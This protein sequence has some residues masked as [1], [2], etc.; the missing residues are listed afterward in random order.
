MQMSHTLLAPFGLFS[1]NDL[2]WKEQTDQHCLYPVVVR[3][4]VGTYNSY[5]APRWQNLKTFSGTEGNTWLGDLAAWCNEVVAVLQTLMKG[6]MYKAEIDVWSGLWDRTLTMK[7]MLPCKDPG[8]KNLLTITVENEKD[9]CER[10]LSVWDPWKLAWTEM[11]KFRR[12]KEQ[13]SNGTHGS[14]RPHCSWVSWLTHLPW[15]QQ[16]SWKDGTRH[17]FLGEI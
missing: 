15:L 6:T 13:A 1:I 4:W 8:R 14:W 11:A 10:G 3:Q 12:C 9:C 7:S 5:T 16:A 2:E 17:W